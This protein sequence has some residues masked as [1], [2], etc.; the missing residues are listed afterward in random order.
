[1]EKKHKKFNWIFFDLDGTL[2]DSIPALYKVH[3]DFLARFGLVCNKEEFEKLNGPSLLEIIIFL[4]NKYKLVE[5][6]N[7]LI[8]L[9]RSATLNAYR[10]Y[11]K[12]HDGLD[13]M[14]KELKHRGYKLVLVTSADR[15][16]AME[17]IN[18]QKLGKYFQDYIF[19][20]EVKKAKPDSAIY[21]LALKK[22]K[23]FSDS[24]AVIEDSYNGVKSAKAANIFVIGLA[25]NQTKEDLLSAGADI[26]VSN[27]KNILSIL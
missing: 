15:E 12:S 19:G 11:V 1:M 17:F 21:D 6:K 5:D 20:D 7:Y 16:I 18:S 3:K 22:I 2:A 26:I 27:L 10:N 23:A 25:N 14:L 9:Y 4:K 13:V 24:V 8:N